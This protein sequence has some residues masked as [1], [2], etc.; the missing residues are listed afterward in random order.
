MKG[1]LKEI[2]KRGVSLCLSALT[3]FSLCVSLSPLFSEDQPS[4][5]ITASAETVESS[6]FDRQTKEDMNFKFEQGAAVYKRQLTEEEKDD[7]VENRALHA[8]KYTLLL[9]NVALENFLDHKNDGAFNWFTLYR[10]EHNKVTPIYQVVA[11][12]YSSG[13]IMWGH[14]KLGFDANVDTNSDIISGDIDFTPEQQTGAAVIGRDNYQNYT[15]GKNLMEAGQAWM[16][17]FGGYT[18]DYI[19]YRTGEEVNVFNYKENEQYGCPS[20]GF[21]INVDSPYMSYF[22]G[23]SYIYKDFVRTET[24]G[25]LWWKKTYSVFNTYEGNIH[26]DTR[27]VATIL[28]NM[29]AAGAL[30]EELED[31]DL[32]AEAQDI[33]SAYEHQSVKI[34]YLK[35]FGDDIPFA[36]AQEVYATVPVRLT[37]GKIYYDD[38]VSYLGYELNA[39]GSNVEGFVYN[40]EDDVYV[41]KYYKNVHLVAKTADGNTKNYFLDINL[42]YYDYYYNMVQDEIFSLDMYEYVL[43]KIMNKYPTLKN[44]DP[45]KLHGYFGYVSIPNTYS[46]NSLWNDIFDKGTA[47][48]GFPEHFEYKEDLTYDAYNKLLGSYG[49]SW[50]EK[51][52]NSVIGALSKDGGYAALHYIFYCHPEIDEAVISQ[53]GSTDPDNNDGALENEIKD[54]VE[55]VVDEVADTVGTAKD[56]NENASALEKALR[57]LEIILGVAIIGA[58]I[59][60]VV[61][62]VRKVKKGKS[63]P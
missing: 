8:M 11:Y 37:T 59:A 63:K 19:V 1:K 3:A 46:W 2:M 18:F 7:G 34:R 26:S 14:K 13:I 24:T 52:W 41:A 32:I 28:T 45:D 25:T 16:E 9:K 31:A 56:L 21:T 47:F 49:Y 12:A 4:G 38:V 33:I 23:Y 57:N 40:E 35:P 43:S 51:L 42:S 39:L 17:S 36:E 10:E 61:L 48:K 62:I 58:A 5:A 27:A 55:G 44:I 20:I 29:N 54:T 6:K 22:V 53:N 30:E 50:F 15:D 60:G